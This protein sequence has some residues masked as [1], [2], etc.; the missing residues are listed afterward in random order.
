MDKGSSCF[1]RIVLGLNSVYNL[2]FGAITRGFQWVCSPNV[3]RQAS[4]VKKNKNKKK[5]T[6]RQCCCRTNHSGQ[7]DVFSLGFRHVGFHSVYF[8]CRACSESLWCHI[9]TLMVSVCCCRWATN[10]NNNKLQCGTIKCLNPAE[11]FIGSHSQL[12]HSSSE[13]SDSC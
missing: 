7:P 5:P 12:S 3:F 6:P 8:C 4:Y 11:I 1:L 10:N 13:M 9:W 2:I